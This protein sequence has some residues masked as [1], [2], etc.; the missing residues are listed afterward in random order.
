[1]TENAPRW[2]NMV[3][4]YLEVEG[5]LRTALVGLVGGDMDFK[6]VNGFVMTLETGFTFVPVNVNGLGG[7]GGG[8]RGAERID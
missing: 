3:G 5:C 6:T 8:G 1:M 2:P 7:G 4:S